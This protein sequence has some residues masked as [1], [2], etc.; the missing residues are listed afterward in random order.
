M[1]FRKIDILGTDWAKCGVW[2]I[3][4]CVSGR[5]AGGILFENELDV[6]KAK[7]MISCNGMASESRCMTGSGPYGESTEGFKNLLESGERVKFILS[8]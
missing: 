4:V 2:G 7:E 3:E 6:F 8:G 1:R 5:I